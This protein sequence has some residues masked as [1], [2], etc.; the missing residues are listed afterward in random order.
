MFFVFLSAVFI[1]VGIASKKEVDTEE[2]IKKDEKGISETPNAEKII[3]EVMDENDEIM[4]FKTF[5][6]SHES[7]FCFAI[8]VHENKKKLLVIKH[9]DNVNYLIANNENAVMQE[10]EG[11]VYGDPY[12][13]ISIED[14]QLVMHYYGGSASWRWIRELY[15]DI[16]DEDIILSKYI[17][18]YF[19]ANVDNQEDI[20]KSIGG[21]I[22]ELDFIK[23]VKIDKKNNNNKAECQTEKMKKYVFNIMDFNISDFIEKFDW[24][25]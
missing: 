14:G 22:K 9:K 16:G 7:F 17:F 10:D 8:I 13:G 15:F 3:K 11:G 24:E 18:Y 23:G 20:L 1:M 21:N 25:E 2:A 6:G 19:H 12:D 4:D 5:T